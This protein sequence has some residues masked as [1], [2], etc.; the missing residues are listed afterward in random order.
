MVANNPS[1]NNIS[2]VYW[3]SSVERKLVWSV[4]HEVRSGLCQQSREVA[5]QCKKIN[6]CD[7]LSAPMVDIAPHLSKSLSP[8][9]S[10]NEK[11]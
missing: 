11:G 4:I 6:M 5:Q 3:G 1:R 10:A 8:R 9:S 2:T 7:K